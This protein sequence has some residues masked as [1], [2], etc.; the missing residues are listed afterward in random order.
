MKKLISFLLICC[1]LISTMSLPAVAESIERMPFTDIQFLH[2]SGYLNIQNL[3]QKGIIDG[4]SPTKFAPEDPLTREEVAK[5]IVLATEKELVDKKGTFKDVKAGSWYEPYVETAVANDIVKG[6]GDGNFGVGGKITRQDAVVLI[7]R[8]A[9]AMGIKLEHLTPTSI[10]D[11]ANIADYAL[12]YVQILTDM[13]ALD[14]VDGRFLPKDPIT[15]M[16]FCITLDRVLISDVRAYDD[17]IQDWIPVEKDASE[18]DS[19]TVVYEDFEDGIKQLNEWKYGYGSNPASEYITKDMGKD[20]KS[21]LK[22]NITPSGS[23]VN[24]FMEG[25]EPSTTYYVSYDIKTEGLDNDSFARMNYE[26]G[27]AMGPNTGG[28]YKP[29]NDIGGDNDWVRHSHQV[30]S[31]APDLSPQFLRMVLSIRGTTQGT[32]YLDNLEIY[33]VVYEPVTTYL[34]SPSFK[35]LI[36]DP[37]GESDIILTS[38]ITGMGSVYEPEKTKLEVSVSDLDG[39]V[40]M[41]SEHIAPTDEMDVTFSSKSLDVGDYDLASK[42]INIETGRIIG[43]NHY[44]LRKRPSDFTSKYGFDE[45]GR[46]LN[47]GK[48]WLPFGAYAIGNERSDLDDFAGT[49]IDFLICN[50]QARFYTNYALLDE[51]DKTDVKLM[52]T[53]DSLF[54]SA[55]R[56]ATQNPDITTIASERAVVDRILDTIDLTNRDCFIGYQINN[57]SSPLQWASRMGW[58]QQHLS[59]KDFDHLTYGVS[60]GGSG[61]AAKHSRMQDI[62]TFDCYPITGESTDPIWEI[63]EGTKPLAE[64]SYN[65][66]VWTSL[67]VSDLKLMGTAAYINRERGPNEQELRNMAW[68]AICGGAQGIVWYA[69]FHVTR[70]DAGRPKSETFPEYL[71]VTD[72]VH[73]FEDVILSREDTPDLYANADRMDRFAYAV[74]RYNGRTYVFLVN[75]DISSQTVSVKLDDVKSIEGVYNNKKKYTATEDGFIDVLLEPLGVEILV[76]DQPEPKS[77]D[78]NLKNVHFTNGEKNYFVSVV[79]DADDSITVADCATQINYNVTMHKDATLKINGE[80]VSNKGTV[81]IEGVDKLTLTITSEDGKHKQDYVYNIIRTP[82]QAE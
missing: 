62:Y 25:V 7:G 76:V 61:T 45:Y 70:A 2:T 55:L 50:S 12:D 71:R 3:W 60:I 73:S 77:A 52:Y 22:L 54:A 78:C 53:V 5:I 16:D 29:A 39:K 43:E 27:I 31:P 8:M 67:Q 56:T 37:E 32:V 10:N 20:S 40:L 35:G 24:V 51:W 21:S 15:R 48:P 80:T 75:S 38:Y 14:L 19:Q 17:I 64:E 59:E 68:Q 11:K 49:N 57:E 23:V 9:D 58:R 47:E 46:L 30:T 1:L 41:N 82:K 72:E 13:N 79:K 18:L 44:M 66:P 34:K 69:H 63:W 4:K 33:K 74:R 65:R 81:S 6:L 36:T 28:G 42:L 26:W